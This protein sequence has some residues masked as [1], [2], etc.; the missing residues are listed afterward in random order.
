MPKVY[1]IGGPNGAGK[2]TAALKLLRRRL[3]CTEFVNADHIARGLSPLH[4]EAV[5]IEAGR[6]MLK[7]IDE[8]ASAGADFSFEA[9][10]ASRTLAPRLKQLRADGFEIHVLFL[11]LRDPD[12]AVA[13]VK[14]RVRS[15]GHAIPEDVIRRRYSRSISNFLNL[16]SRLA[17]FWEIHD[18]SLEAAILIAVGGKGRE[19]QVVD[20][21]RWTRVQMMKEKPEPT[22]MFGEGIREAVAEAIEEHRRMRR[23][24]WVMRD[25]K[26]TEIPPDQIKPLNPDQ[27]MPS[28][29]A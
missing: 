20:E 22:S 23:S 5:G 14:A 13:R 1:V 8:L 24:I 11:W 17:D 29:L 9:T 6:L 2:S 12:L 26:V 18:N 4:P 3:D 21:R 16:Y 25:G 15:G 28:S 19:E 7:R 10:L 27:P